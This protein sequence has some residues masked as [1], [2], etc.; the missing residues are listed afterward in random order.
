MARALYLG[1]NVA[2]LA[3]LLLASITSAP[4]QV[5]EWVIDSAM[6]TAREKLATCTIGNNIYALGGSPGED[7]QPLDTV[8]RLNTVSGNWAAA[9]SMAT[10]RSFLTAAVVD[11]ICYAIWGRLTFGTSGYTSVVSI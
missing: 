10:Q 7:A 4:A 8:E 5:G 3:A 9:P 2:S 6:P 1:I 11:G